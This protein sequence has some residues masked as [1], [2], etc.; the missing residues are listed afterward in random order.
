M[1]FF[2]T[3]SGSTLLAA[4]LAAGMAS[5]IGASTA[6]AQ[7]APNAAP[8]SRA[9]QGT[10]PSAAAADISGQDLKTFAVAAL[11]VKKINDS[12]RPRYQ[13]A[14][15]PEA[16]QQVQKEATDKMAAAVQDKG[17]TVDKY[18]QIVHVAQADPEVAQQIDDYAKQAK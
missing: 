16:K 15:T 1:R 11:E 5:G 17:L 12:Y 18:N 4:A 2:R 9:S 7:P 10:P 3:A 8:A 13:S 14:D 6:F